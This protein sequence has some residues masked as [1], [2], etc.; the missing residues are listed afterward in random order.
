MSVEHDALLRKQIHDYWDERLK[1]EAEEMRGHAIPKP[2][3]PW[4]IR[5]FDWLCKKV[6]GV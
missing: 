1:R 6:D 5:L 4:F 2:V 3:D